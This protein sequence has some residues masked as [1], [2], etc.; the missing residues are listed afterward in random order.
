MMEQRD[1]SRI[2]SFKSEFIQ[3]RLTTIS[4]I[5][6]P[7]PPTAARRKRSKANKVQ[8]PRRKA[9]GSC[10][11][12]IQTTSRDAA[13]HDRKVTINRITRELGPFFRRFKLKK[14]TK[15]TFGVVQKD[16]NR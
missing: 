10:A 9:I 8:M 12:W 15:F 3:I 4:A 5:W 2:H 13:N 7:A 6:W 11:R 14:S 1:E 16:T